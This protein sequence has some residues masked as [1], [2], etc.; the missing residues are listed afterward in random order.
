MKLIINSMNKNLF[1]LCSIV[2]TFLIFSNKGFSS[3]LDDVKCLKDKG[4][5]MYGAEWCPNCQKQKQLFGEYFSYINY[6]DCEENPEICESKNL[7]G[8]PTWLLPN[9]QEV[10]PGTIGEVA[11]G[12]GCTENYAQVE[13]QTTQDIQDVQTNPENEILINTDVVEKSKDLLAAECLKE[14]NITMYGTEWCPHCKHQK[15]IFGEY[16]SYIN[17]VNCDFDKK[18]CRK[19]KITGYPT[20]LL[21]NGTEIPPGLSVQESAIK[22]GCVL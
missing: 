4:I 21:P 16:F 13:N 18:T 10:E 3:E 14:K 20:I 17:F 6:V 11:R 9:G 1:Y 8:Y 5:T 7:Q 19:A 15:E 12:A 22:A 2:F